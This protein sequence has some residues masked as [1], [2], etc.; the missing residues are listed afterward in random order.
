MNTYW[1]MIA[2]IGIIVIELFEVGGALHTADQLQEEN[3]RLKKR[4]NV[5]Q[6]M[7]EDTYIEA[8]ERNDFLE[9]ISTRR[10]SDGESAQSKS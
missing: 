1:L 3:R 5:L 2:L 4:L 8:Q 9:R 6:K 10:A 7:T